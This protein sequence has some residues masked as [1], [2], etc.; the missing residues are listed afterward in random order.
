MICA[1]IV[2]NMLSNQAQDSERS[3]LLLIYMFFLFR[4]KDSTEGMPQLISC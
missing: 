2:R 3:G 1:Y 4:N